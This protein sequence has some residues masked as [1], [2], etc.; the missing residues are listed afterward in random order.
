MSDD[1]SLGHQITLQLMP[2][3]MLV[4]AI[5]S[6]G[7]SFW[8]PPFLL[9]ALCFTLVVYWLY[10]MK[11]LRFRWKDLRFL[12]LPA[13]IFGTGYL[14]YYHLVPAFYDQA[15]H[16]Q[17]SNRILDRWAWEPT[18]QGMSYSFRPEIIPGV[19][20]V[21]L[22]LTGDVST[23]SVT[24][25][26]LLISTAWSIQHVGEHFSNSKWG[27]ISGAAF[28]LLP[29]TVMYGRTMLLD[30]AVAGMIIS[31]FHHLHIIPNG[32]RN[33]YILIGVLAAIVGL[34]KYPYLYLGGWISIV[35]LM[36]K[37]TR[38]SKYISY[39]Y[40]A[41]ITLF[42]LKNQIH[43]GWILGPLQSQI[44][45]TI[46]SVITTDSVAYSPHIFMTD[47][48]K[49]WDIFLICAAL[50]GVALIA[51]KQ[52]EYISN[53]WLFILPAIILHG[54]IL[55]FGW[56]RYSTPW[57]A[58]LCI[59]IPAALVHSNDEFGERIR[60]LK[61]PS[62]LIGILIIAS[63]GPVL[64]NIEEIEPM[65]ESWYDSKGNWADI[66][67]HVG[68]E[69]SEQTTIITGKDITMGL[70]SQM[71][72]YRY[73]DPEYPMLQAINKFDPTH[74]FTQ[75]MQ[76]RYGIDV[77][78]TFLF[79]SPIEPVKVFS[80]DKYVGR[81]WEVDQS[82][83]VQSDWWRNST[84]EINGS[85]AH[86]GDFI[87]LENGSNFEL[88]EDTA[89][90]R[91]FETNSERVLGGIFETLVQNRQNLLCDSLESCSEYS[92]TDHLEHNWAV[93]MIK[94]DSV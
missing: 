8:L 3:L 15:Y 26:L 94:V 91:I 52:S 72:C 80:S 39:G 28:C 20:A 86:Y 90:H 78:S 38:E 65:S 27:F 35:Y 33:K 76:Y 77:N 45:G 21:E 17:I 68:F 84:I 69:F 61:A 12:I 43:T 49:Q 22:W 89:I 2:V 10:T 56:P 40:L 54:Y 64:E 46:A 70:Y 66:Y 6:L 85:G 67:R 36:R 53:Y 31:V 74:V 47:F 1:L 51:K 30:V 44:T 87:W 55:D 24:P 92:R 18:H 25:T 5:M 41:I 37:K 16:L 9:I 50:Y 42:L 75:D 23:V 71:P 7:A 19:A 32:D 13:L 81:L 88:L 14:T 73:E 58:L 4:G 48:V 29:I 82:R 59:G 63:I 60:Q 34:T 62:F 93:W 83:L 57:L 11:D 79:G